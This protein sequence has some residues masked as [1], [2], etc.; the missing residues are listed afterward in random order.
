L[1][2]PV[3]AEWPLVRSHEGQSLGGGDY[4]HNGVSLLLAGLELGLTG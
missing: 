4:R 3:G 1:H 2:F